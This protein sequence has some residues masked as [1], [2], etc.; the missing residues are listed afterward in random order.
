MKHI[1]SIALF[2]TFLSCQSQISTQGTQPESRIET[3]AE[4]T[5]QYIELLKG[6]RVGVVANQTSRIGRTH[7][8][9]TLLAR[10]INITTVFAPEHG[11][12]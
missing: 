6:K 5:E 2:A 12:R 1:L 3:G 11:F 4:Q 7:L 9:D 10:G 8:V